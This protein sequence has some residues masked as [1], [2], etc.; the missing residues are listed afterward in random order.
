VHQINFLIAQFSG[1]AFAIVF[2]KCLS[3]QRVSVAVRQYTCL[4]AGALIGYFCF[5]QQIYNLL[6]LTTL[7]YIAIL[8]CSPNVVQR[9]VLFVALMYL[10]YLHL[11]RLF[12]DY[13]G[14]TI[15][16]TGPIMIAVQKVTNVGFSLHD[17]L[18]K[19][20]D[21][22]TADQK[23][24]A[25]RCEKANIS[26]RKEL[27]E[28]HPKQTVLP[29]YAIASGLYPSLPPCPLVFYNDY[30]EFISGKNF[31]RHIQSKLSSRPMPSPLLLW[32][33][34]RK[35]FVSVSFAVLL[36]TIAPMFPITHLT[37]DKFLDET[38]FISKLVYILCAT[39]MA[40]FKYYHAWI[41]GEVICNASGL[42]FAAVTDDSRA[43][44]SACQAPTPSVTPGKLWTDWIAN[45][46][47]TRSG[48]QVYTGSLL[49]KPLS[50]STGLPIDQ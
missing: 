18:A 26:G 38:S 49:F 33:V 48:A 23:R 31:E 19:S 20:E 46:M 13:G 7:S 25:I 15:D 45:A 2:R 42:G 30:I 17:G 9:V 44:T 41:L 40:R 43:T 21:T 6:I 14:Y 39:C 8:T 12:H 27:R 28:T 4:I 34:L 29:S 11:L 36:V 16:I 47:S 3:H 1:L 5:G 32:A 35:L 50:T 22:L 24:Y 37:E 10:S